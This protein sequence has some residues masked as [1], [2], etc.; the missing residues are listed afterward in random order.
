MW[1]NRCCS[2]TAREKKERIFSPFRM[3]FSPNKFLL[4]NFRNEKEKTIC[5]QR[6]GGGDEE[7]VLSHFLYKRLLFIFFGY[8]Y[9]HTR[10]HIQTLC[11][12]TSCFKLEISFELKLA[13]KHRVS[14]TTH[15]LFHKQQQDLHSIKMHRFGWKGNL[16]IFFPFLLAATVL[17]RKGRREEKGERQVFLPFSGPTNKKPILTKQ[18]N[19]SKTDDNVYYIHTSSSSWKARKK[20]TFFG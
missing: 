8:T 3:F 18:Q 2:K 10:T 19:T 13:P 17:Q 16:F 5:L 1:A 6:G 11:H 20:T 12:K 14:K 15:D 4:Q 9:A 7:K